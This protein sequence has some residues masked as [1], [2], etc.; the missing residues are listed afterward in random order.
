MGYVIMKAMHAT[1]E[2]AVGKHLSVLVSES[3][4]SFLAQ[5]IHL[6]KISLRAVMPVLFNSLALPGIRK[7]PAPLTRLMLRARTLEE[8]AAGTQ[9]SDAQDVYREQK[10]LKFWVNVASATTDVALSDF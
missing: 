2:A 7:A 3:R 5:A 4:S 1:E 9:M 6:E 10:R 8:L